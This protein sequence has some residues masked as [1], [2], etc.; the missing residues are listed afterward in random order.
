[1]S[2]QEPETYSGLNWTA[3]QPMVQHVT[4]WLWL[5][6]IP[7]TALCWGFLPGTCDNLT[8]SRVAQ[9]KDP[10]LV[11]FRGVFLGHHWSS[12]PWWP[13]QVSNIGKHAQG[14]CQIPQLQNVTMK[15]QLRTQCENLPWEVWKI[16]GV[17]VLSKPWTQIQWAW[18]WRAIIISS[19][20]HSLLPE[21]GF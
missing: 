15:G 19:K 18:P 21:R 1:M 4:S 20:A 2:L 9:R 14:G 11:Q 5:E 6:K 16:K 7:K 17:M 8:L 3:Q 10:A 13:G 12:S